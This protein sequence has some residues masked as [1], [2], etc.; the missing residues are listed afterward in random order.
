MTMLVHDS[1][2]IPNLA[3]ERDNPQAVKDLLERARS[4]SQAP[5]SQYAVGAVA[6]A[7]SGNAYLGTNLEFTNQPLAQTVHA[8]QF[9]LTLARLH[10][11]TGIRQLIV[12]AIPCGHCRQFLM[13]LK[14]PELPIVVVDDHQWT[15]VVLKDLLP[16]PFVLDAHT[17]GMLTY[18]EAPLRFHTNPSMQELAPT[19]LDA[20]SYAYVPYTKAYSGVAIRLEN[21]EIYQGS[22]IESAAYNPTLPALQAALIHVISNQRQFGEIREVLLL[23]REDASHSLVGTV[24]NLIKAVSPL[25]QI[26]FATTVL[27]EL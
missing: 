5:I 13:E 9:A 27:D 16:L 2:C 25:A 3:V 11:E 23:E 4:F 14:Q 22:T 1:F 24:W 10:G 20:A 17:P 15:E 6:I 8:E 26:E 18:D 19:A 21:G 12:S 7:E